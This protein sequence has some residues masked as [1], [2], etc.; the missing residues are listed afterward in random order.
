MRRQ[1]ALSRFGSLLNP[2]PSDAVWG[3]L[4]LG[5][6]ETRTILCVDGVPVLVRTTGP[7]GEAWTAQI[8]EAL[9]ISVKAAE[10]QKRDAGLALTGRGVRAEGVATPAGELAAILTGVLRN[11][12]QTLAGEVKRSY[13]Y[14]LSCYPRRRA[15]DLV[16][17]GGGAVTKN[18]AEYL[19]QALGIPVCPASAWL[20]RDGCRLRFAS[21]RQS[22]IEE[23]ALAVGVAIES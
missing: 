3:I 22:R 16:L 2:W 19:A 4:D 13:E 8:A 17:V 12:L 10:V 20:S 21:G 9:E 15:A 14:V 1:R 23:L 5:L 18:L 6:R 7:G 11:D